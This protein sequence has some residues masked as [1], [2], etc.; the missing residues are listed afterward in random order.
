M[1]NSKA[2]EHPQN[3][4]GRIK[5]AIQWYAKKAI[6]QASVS[7]S[8]VNRIQIPIPPI[9]KQQKIADCLPSL[10]DEIKAQ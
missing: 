5:K 6:N 2:T 1:S 9:P 4:E 8:D 3:R 10:N 7:T